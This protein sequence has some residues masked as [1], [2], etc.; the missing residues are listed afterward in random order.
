M[1]DLFE[2]AA[3]AYYEAGVAHWKTITYPEWIDADPHLK[4]AIRTQA[5]VVMAVV[6]KATLEEAAKVADRRSGDL[7]ASQSSGHLDA[8]RLSMKKLILLDDSF[9]IEKLR[10][11]V[12]R[13]RIDE[14]E[15]IAAAIRKLGEE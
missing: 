13:K 11:L 12:I 14:A 15:Y 8:E 1:S 2:R 4:E 5:R 9:S 7:V 3:R 10:R 6:R